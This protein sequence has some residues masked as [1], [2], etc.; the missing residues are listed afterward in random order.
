[1]IPKFRAWDKESKTISYLYVTYNAEY[2]EVGLCTY[3]PKKGEQH[4]FILS[5]EE[6]DKVKGFIDLKIK[7]AEND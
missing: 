3:Q 1:M 5:L 2:G 4:D 6:W 7:E